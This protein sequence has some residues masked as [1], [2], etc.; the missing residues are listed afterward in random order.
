MSVE[1]ATLGWK[2]PEKCGIGG[3][4]GTGGTEETDGTNTEVVTPVT[5]VTP[6]KQYSRNAPI[7]KYYNLFNLEQCDGIASPTQ[8]IPTFEFTPIEKAEHIVSGMK[9]RP[10]ISYGGNRASYSPMLD[11]IRMPYEDRFE[12]SEEFYSVLFHE[13]GH[14]TGHKS[15]LARKEVMATNEFRSETH[16]SEEIVAELTSSMLCGVAGISNQTIE[17]AASYLDVFPLCSYNSARK[18]CSIGGISSSFETVRRYS[19]AFVSA[20]IAVS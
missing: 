12:K 1:N 10:E 14:S 11:K 18:S 13:M 4:G 16:G 6:E 9:D 19:F 3:T 7:L 5:S 20:A 15:R 17:L 2:Y 8:E